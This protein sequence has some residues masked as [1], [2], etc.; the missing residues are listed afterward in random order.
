MS[1]MNSYFENQKKLFIQSKVKNAPNPTVK[2]NKNN[3]R[4]I[5]YS[6][7]ETEKS[8]KTDSKQNNSK[9][10]SKLNK[11]KVDSKQN[12]SKADSKQNN[13][14]D[15]SKPCSPI[16]RPEEADN[17]SGSE[18]YPSEESET[19]NAMPSTSKSAASRSTT[20]LPKQHDDGN[21]DRFNERIKEWKQNKKTKKTKKHTESLDED[22][23]EDDECHELPG[24]LMVPNCIWKR[25]Y[26]Y[27]KTGVKWLW[28]L[29]QMESGGLLGDEMGLGKTIQIIAFLVG[30]SISRMGTWYGLGPTLIVA[31]ATVL[32][33]WVLHFHEWWPPL[34]VAVLHNSG[35]HQGVPERLIRDIHAANGIL[36]T[37]YT[38]IVKHRAAIEDRKWHYII[39]DEG[40]KI[41]NSE[42][43]VSKAVRRIRTPHRLV[44]T[45]SPMQN[46]LQELWS[47]FDFMSP[48]LLGTLNAFSD[49]FAS[50]ITQGGYT[51]ASKLQEAS[52]LSLATVLKDTITPYMLRRTK[53]QVK[54]HLK[55][56]DKKEQ[57]LFC[58][59]SDEQ[60]DLYKSYLLSN[61][62]RGIL[63]KECRFGDPVRARILVALCILRKICNHP[64]LFICEVDEDLPE[65]GTLPTDV[66]QSFGYWK[67]AGKMV[68]IN[69]L[70]KIW[71]KQGHRV[72][73]FT[74]SR[75]MICILELFLQQNDYKYLKMDGTTSIGSRQ[76]MITAFNSDESYLVFLATTRVGGLGVNLTGADRVIIYDPDWNP[77]ID[78]QAKERA[79]RIGQNRDVTIY[80]LLS[81]GTVEEKIYQRQVFKQLL[82]NKVFLD[83]KQKNYLKTS[84]LQGLFSLE[85]PDKAG[86]TETTNIFK[87]TQIKSNKVLDDKAILSGGVSFSK[88]KMDAMRRLAQQISKNMSSANCSTANGKVDEEKEDPRERYNK[89]R[90]PAPPV[91]E[92]PLVNMHNDQETKANFSTVLSEIDIINM[93]SKPEH[94]DYL[95]REPHEE[96]E[97][98]DEL[99]EV[100]AL[101]NTE[102]E[103]LE[104]KEKISENG[105]LH[106]TTM[107]NI[108][109]VHDNMPSNLTHIKTELQ[110]DGEI[111][112]DDIM[113][114]ITEVEKPNSTTHLKTEE[115]KDSKIKI[116]DIPKT[117]KFTK[118]HITTAHHPTTTKKRV[119]EH[120]SKN[121]KKRRRKE[122]DY[123]S[124]L[125]ENGLN[126]D[127]EFRRSVKKVKRKKDRAEPEVEEDPDQYVLEKLFA[128]S[129]VQSALQ[130]DK[131]VG[132]SEQEENCRMQSQA[133]HRAVLALK[134]LRKSRVKNWRW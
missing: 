3:A 105:V 84:T 118:K 106:A 33:Q 43:L 4:M 22:S 93:Y 28:E 5:S 27:Q 109:E 12:N 47:L 96:G 83:P 99:E 88:T 58:S 95:E 59:L 39:L 87:H 77:A 26:R 25:L 133:H 71:K 2:T 112:E 7:D 18:Y 66:V 48:G 11:S 38:G 69:S 53:A 126:E 123:E 62:V 32:H 65:D 16:R 61:A 13:Q 117:L 110:E 56:P 54:D 24:G 15:D 68:V 73:I 104:S 121:G 131:V 132:L 127:E 30:L 6:S 78:S 85:E 20:K 82:G 113:E 134:A 64:D 89:S 8:N 72:L 49:H 102:L 50:P 116:C 29:H 98:T 23:N 128:K 80:R 46:N 119:S 92:E 34:R 52:A 86:S 111:I 129:G 1:D 63:D 36:V 103:T 42:T 79:W 100:E 114:E 37:T 41:R 101:S 40:H 31:P 57:V 51:N 97:I 35:S 91:P 17:G 81:A 44:V 21:V 76:P 9:A 74:Q 67:R 60:K 107:H 19:D 90:L 94:L 115:S 14:K 108:T 70:L 120:K 75:A 122:K 130:H 45:G 55:L 125:N 10:D 124:L